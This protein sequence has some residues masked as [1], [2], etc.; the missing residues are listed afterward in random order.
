[1][2]GAVEQCAC[3]LREK[4]RRQ[5]C[6]GTLA[7]LTLTHDAVLFRQSEDFCEALKLAA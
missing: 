6:R 1:M 7:Q 5:S 3:S 2:I 4:A